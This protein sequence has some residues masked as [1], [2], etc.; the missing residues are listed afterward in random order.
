MGPPLF[1]GLLTIKIGDLNRKVQPMR[2]YLLFF[3]PTEIATRGSANM[4]QLM[5]TLV[6][7]GP[8]VLG[9]YG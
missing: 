5:V 7:W 3:G 2:P 8:V 1:G 9:F 4:I 6:V